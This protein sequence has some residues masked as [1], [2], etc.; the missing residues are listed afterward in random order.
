MAERTDELGLTN[1]FGEDDDSMGGKSAGSG[2]AVPQSRIYELIHKKINTDSQSLKCPPK[3]P[4]GF[5]PKVRFAIELPLQA[6]QKYT[7]PNPMGRAKQNLYPITLFMSIIWIW[8]LTYMI[9]WWTY[10]LTNV[11][12]LHYSI[13]PMILYPLGISIRDRKKFYDFQLA[14]QVF[15]DKLQDQEI[16]LA[17]TYSGPIFQI[18]GLVGFAW[19]FY[20]VSVGNPVKFLNES[21]QYQAPML[22]G[23]VIVKYICLAISKFKSKRALFYLNTSGYTLFLIVAIL[24]DYKQ[25]IFG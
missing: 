23:V 18:T 11:Y 10:T 14:L 13:I 2:S 25:E 20:I 21:I 6:L 17:E 9:V 12:N 7:I 16:S 22:L 8:G 4:K 15:K 19:F 24:L 5:W 1:A 3:I